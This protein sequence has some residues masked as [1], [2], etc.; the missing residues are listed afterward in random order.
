M[1]DYLESTGID[2]E[3]IT[4][5]NVIKEA[6]AAKIIID[7]EMW[8]DML[9]KRNALAHTYSEITFGKAVEKIKKII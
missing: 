8:I 7:G 3:T 1:R 9:E 6:F 4:P 5:K 2:I